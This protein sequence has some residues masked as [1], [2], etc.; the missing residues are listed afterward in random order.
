MGDLGTGYGLYYG[1]QFFGMDELQ[2]GSVSQLIVFV[3]VLMTWVSTYLFRVGS[4]VCR[5]TSYHVILMCEV[6]DF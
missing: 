5:V 6:R 1:L 2:A 3:F 4:K